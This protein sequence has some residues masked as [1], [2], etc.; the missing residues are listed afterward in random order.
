LVAQRQAPRHSSYSAGRTPFACE[1]LGQFRTR[2]RARLGHNPNLVL[3]LDRPDAPGRFTGMDED[4]SP[5]ATSANAFV[6]EDQFLR[7]AVAR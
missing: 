7:P 3:D 6:A 1:K 2:Q 4:Y 5:P